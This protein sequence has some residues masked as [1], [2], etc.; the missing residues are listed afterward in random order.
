MKKTFC[1]LFLTSF[2][3]ASCATENH[4]AAAPEESPKSPG[5]AITT[6]PWPMS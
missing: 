3:L 5:P 6:F 1:F 2:L 4:T